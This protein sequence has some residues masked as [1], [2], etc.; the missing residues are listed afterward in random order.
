MRNEPTLT[1][2][3]AE[4][5]GESETAPIGGQIPRPNGTRRQKACSQPTFVN[6][7]DDMSAQDRSRPGQSQGPPNDRGIA[8]GEVQVLLVEGNLFHAG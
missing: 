3:K 6:P 4:P 5:D 2:A 1:A 8:N 7:I